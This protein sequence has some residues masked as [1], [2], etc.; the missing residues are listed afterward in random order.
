[1]LVAQGTTNRVKGFTSTQMQPLFRLTLIPL[2]LP[3]L[4]STRHNKLIIHHLGHLKL[5]DTTLNRDVFIL[6]TIL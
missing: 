2:H 1:M 3:N 5:F 6:V 4:A